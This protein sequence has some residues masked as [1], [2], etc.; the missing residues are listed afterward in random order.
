MIVE[1]GCFET[2]HAFFSPDMASENFQISIARH[3]VEDFVSWP[4]TKHGNY[5]VRSAYY[6]ACSNKKL[7]PRDSREGKHAKCQGCGERLEG[8]MAYQGAGQDD[9]SS[10]AV[11][12]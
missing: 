4:F 2:V 5:T 12:A 1:V 7:S 8:F 9:H 11:C 10:K 3:G 6:F